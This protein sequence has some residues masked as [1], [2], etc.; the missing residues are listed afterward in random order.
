MTTLAHTTVPK[1]M[2]NSFKSSEVI[3]QESPSTIRAEWRATVLRLL[4]VGSES[5]S[6]QLDTMLRNGTCDLPH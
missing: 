1:G 2:N 5:T 3:D 6:R 4:A